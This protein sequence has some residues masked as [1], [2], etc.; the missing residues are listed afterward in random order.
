[1]VVNLHFRHNILVRILYN[2]MHLEINKIIVKFSTKAGA[3][4][5]RVK[6]Q[7]QKV[8]KCISN[9]LEIYHC[10]DG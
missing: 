10:H 2:T 1:M 8:I 6:S 3:T 5:A 7:G 9:D 4:Y